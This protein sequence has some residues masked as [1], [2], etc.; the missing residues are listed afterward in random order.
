MRWKFDR[1]QFRITLAEF[2]LKPVLL[3]AKVYEVLVNRR[4]NT[5]EAS[6]YARPGMI[7]A[8]ICTIGDGADLFELNS[9]TN[10]ADNEEQD[11]DN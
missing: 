6:S 3:I 10:S 1:A 11:D 7:I 9:S 8:D 5:S 2:E 4:T